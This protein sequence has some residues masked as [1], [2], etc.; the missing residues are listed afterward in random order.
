MM[1]T[2][3]GKG[4]PCTE[5]QGWAVLPARIWSDGDRVAVQYKIA[6]RIVLGQH[7]N[8]GAAVL[9][10]GPFVMAYDASMNPGLPGANSVKL[11][12]LTGA[13]V[14]AGS[15]PLQVTA[16]VASRR[17]TQATPA[18][19]VPFA[20]AGSSGGAYR[21]WLPAP[22]TNAEGAESVLADGRES[23]SR[24]GNAEGSILDDGASQFVV[25]FDGKK[26]D[27]DWFAVTLDHPVTVGRIEFVGGQIFHDG[28]WFDTSGGKPIVQVQ[29]EAGS[30][31]ERLSEISDYPTTTATDC[32]PLIDE[33]HR[34]FTIR[35]TIPQTVFGVRVVGKPACG[36]NPLQAFSSCAG[37][38]AYAAGR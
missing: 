23:R 18:A 31:W 15:S 7:G 3:N 19:F 30:K 11:A 17:L 32:G 5:K 4:H 35:L 2:V 24:Q 26:Q 16:N 12:A 21:V 34:K 38:F 1:V 27:E 10:W 14:V 36:D 29:R 28:G 22:G 33:A 8:T 20:D 13:H 25:T 9:E 6:S 37:L